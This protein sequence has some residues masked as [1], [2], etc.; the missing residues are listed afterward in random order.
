[1]AKI[2]NKII[3]IMLNSNELNEISPPD[4]PKSMEIIKIRH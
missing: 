3:D 4:T 1:M 2:I